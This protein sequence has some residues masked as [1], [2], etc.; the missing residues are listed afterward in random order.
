M[1]AYFI[2]S[3]LDPLTI[4]L[5]IQSACFDDVNDL[6]GVMISEVPT[7]AL[8]TFTTRGST[9]SPAEI[10]IL[11]D[12]LSLVPLVM[13][14]EQYTEY[15]DSTLTFTID[16]SNDDSNCPQDIR[17]VMSEECVCL[18]G[19][20]KLMSGIELTR[21]PYGSSLKVAAHTFKGVGKTHAMYMSTGVVTPIFR[22]DAGALIL[23]VNSIGG[24]P[25]ELIFKLGLDI[26]RQRGIWRDASVINVQ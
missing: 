9:V 18:N 8:G 6:R 15:I 26:M 2:L 1:G 5:S 17:R 25:A 12:R 10:T 16:I 11:K 3:R 21:L 7:L 13:S 20:V 23:T 19:N 24:I 22:N 4:Q 14:E